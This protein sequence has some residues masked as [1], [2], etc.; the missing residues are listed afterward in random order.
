[1]DEE[2]SARNPAAPFVFDANSRRFYHGTQADLKP[3]DLLQPGYSSNYT[4]RISPWIYFNE[5]LHAATWGAEL[6]K[7]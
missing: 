2:I 7:G 4:E 6:A 5:T 1:M 3:G